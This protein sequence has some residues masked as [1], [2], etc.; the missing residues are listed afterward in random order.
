MSLPF[1]F[2]IRIKHPDAEDDRGKLSS[3]YT[4]QDGLQCC[5]D[6]SYQASYLDNVGDGTLKHTVFHT[7][8]KSQ[9][10]QDND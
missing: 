4:S 8:G 10:V 3:D 5:P 9:H 2:F 6:T 1:C 7:H